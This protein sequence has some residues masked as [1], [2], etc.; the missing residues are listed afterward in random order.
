M[1]AREIICILQLATV[2]QRTNFYLPARMA[3]FAVLPSLVR[4]LRNLHAF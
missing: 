3:H 1:T 2:W 4:Q